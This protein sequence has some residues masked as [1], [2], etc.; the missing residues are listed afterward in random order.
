MLAVSEDGIVAVGIIIILAAMSLIQEYQTHR[1]RNKFRAEQDH[2]FSA[3]L[4]NTE[5]CPLCR[6]DGRIKKPEQDSGAPHE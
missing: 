4:Q 6:G 2:V 5:P 1:T 3:Y